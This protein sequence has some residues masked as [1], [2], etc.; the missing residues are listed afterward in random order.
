MR[1]SQGL[2]S[3]YE[4]THGRDTAERGAVAD[5]DQD[6]AALTHLFG[7]FDIVRIADRAFQ[8]AHR[9][10]FLR[11]ML[12]VRYRARGKLNQFR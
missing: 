1:A 6:I 10:A 8:N 12:E 5:R 4:I 11:R 9:Y 2:I 3:T 7:D